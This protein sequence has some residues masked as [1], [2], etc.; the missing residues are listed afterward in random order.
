MIFERHRHKN[1]QWPKTEMHQT[2]EEVE[3]SNIKLHLCLFPIK[4]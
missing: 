4:H 1:Q 2:S 3:T